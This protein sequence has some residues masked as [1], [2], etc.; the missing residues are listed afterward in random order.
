MGPSVVVG[1]GLVGV[2]GPQSGCLPGPALWKLLAT[3]GWDWVTS[4]WLQAPG[5][6]GASDG[7]LVDRVLF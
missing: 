5:S 6:P 4:C 2:A 7:P 3:G 1:C